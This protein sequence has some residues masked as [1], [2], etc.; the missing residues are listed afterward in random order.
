MG[1]RQ[2]P[3]LAGV[4]GLDVFAIAG[5]SISGWYPSY[6]DP[7]AASPRQP[8]TTK[9]EFM[10]GLYLEYH[11]WVRGYQRGD[12]SAAFA[13]AHKLAVPLGTPYPIAYVDD[14][15]PHEYLP[16]YV[17]TLV[18]GG[19]LIAEA[20][21]VDEKGRGTALVKAN[22]ARRWARLKGGVYW[23]GTE[24]TLAPRWHQNLVFLHARQRAF[25][26]F[27][28]IAREIMAL[29]RA[30]GDIP[31]GELVDRLGRRWS[32][33]EVEAAAWKIAGDAAAAGCLVVDLAAEPLDLS[34]PIA[35]LHPDEPPIL[36]DPLPD[37]LDR[38]P[39]GA[40]APVHAAEARPGV[41]QRD[42][43]PLV[44]HG[45]PGPTVDASAIAPDDARAAFLRNLAAVTTWR[46]ANRS[47]PLQATTASTPATCACSSGAPGSTASPP[48]SRT[49]RIAATAR[50]GPSSA[51]LSGSSTRARCAPRSPPSTRTWPPNAWPTS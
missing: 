21:R 39:V 18:N 38:S 44:T 34:T 7:A 9:M 42:D 14:D 19:L 22:A 48:S 24:G 16:D 31:V 35:L 46:R 6:K 4:R 47:A 49:A 45:L 2:E 50:S 15:A 51:P 30:G 25:P 8:F 12:M 26:T 27:A 11:P 20:G 3:S 33:A 32:A 29:W 17:G 23:L 36:S 13:Q 41:E 5:A 1:H 43:S 28:E 40:E 37:T 10:L